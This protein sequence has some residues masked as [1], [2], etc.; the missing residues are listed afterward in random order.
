MYGNSSQ[1]DR[2][3]ATDNMCRNIVN[4]TRGFDICTRYATE[5]LLLVFINIW[6]SKY[7]SVY[8]I[9]GQHD[10]LCPSGCLPLLQLFPYTVA[11][12]EIKYY[13]YRGTE[14]IAETASYARAVYDNVTEFAIKNLNMC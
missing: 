13:Y 9:S 1:K 3:S 14:N 6:S 12:G 8:S 11:H 2:D 5:Q 10:G 4:S 7:Y